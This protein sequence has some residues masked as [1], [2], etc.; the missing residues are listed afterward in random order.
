MG[1]EVTYR[2]VRRVVFKSVNVDVDPDL[3]DDG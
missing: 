2:L 1:E 3:L